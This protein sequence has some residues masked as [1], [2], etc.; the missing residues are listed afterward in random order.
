MELRQLR[1]FAMVAQEL[2]F[3]KAAQKL[4]I[5]QPPLSFQINNLVIYHDRYQRPSRTRTRTHITTGS[6]VN[7]DQ[8]TR[9]VVWRVITQQVKTQH[10]DTTPTII[11]TITINNPVTQV[12]PDQL[13]TIP[14]QVKLRKQP[15]HCDQFQR[16]AFCLALAIQCIQQVHNHGCQSTVIL[17]SLLGL[18]L[19]RPGIFHGQH[20]C[21]NNNMPKTIT[22]TITITGC[23]NHHTSLE[24]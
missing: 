4:N 10:M 24:A 22:R 2:S 6:I 20:H 8:Y 12:L 7:G 3:T 21:F 14:C 13:P 9:G 16:T 1:Y 19:T 11:I 18:M 17:G 15:C 5:S 23:N